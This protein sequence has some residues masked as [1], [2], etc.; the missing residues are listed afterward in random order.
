[1][2]GIGQWILTTDG[3]QKF[4]VLMNVWNLPQADLFSFFRYSGTGDAELREE[5]ADDRQA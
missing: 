2:N 1:M 5:S 4:Y 3:W